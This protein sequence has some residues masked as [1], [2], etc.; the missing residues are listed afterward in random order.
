[1]P[2]VLHEL[3]RT[4]LEEL[5][6]ALSS[7][8]IQPPYS[9]LALR[10][11]LAGHDQG[12]VSSELER[13]RAAGMTSAQIGIVMNLLATERSR[14]QSDQ[15]RIQMVWTGPDQDGPSVRDTGVVARELLSQATRSILLT[16]FS[17]SRDSKTFEPVSEAMIR[18]RNLDVTVILNVDLSRDRLF[19]QQAV[20]KFAADFWET[21]WIWPIRPKVYYDP[22]STAENPMQKALQHSKCVVADVHRL[23]ITSS[24]YTESG[25]LRNVELGVVIKDEVLASRVVEQFRSLIGQGYLRPLPQ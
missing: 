7:G 22:R 9:A 1:M 24:N 15:D 19:G 16:T 2:S 6:R 13:L 3:P 18:N 20:A 5:S 23:L 11:W 25:H 8:R 10:E 17:I 21:K 4:V 14:Q 12:P